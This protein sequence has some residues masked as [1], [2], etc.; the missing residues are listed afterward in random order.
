MKIAAFTSINASY[1]PNA[2]ILAKSV[3]RFQPDWD[4]YLLFNDW[5][6]DIIRWENE[7]F[8][9][10]VFADWLDTGGDWFRWA[11]K[12]SVVEFCTATKGVMSQYLLKNLRYDAVVYIDPDT[13]LFSPLEEVITEFSEKTAD[14]ILTPHLTDRE[15]DKEG[16]ASHEMAALKHGTFNLGFFAILNSPNGNKF[17]DWWADRL[18]KYSFIDFNSGLFTDQKWCNL[19][20]YIFDGVKVFTH[21]TYNVATWNMI[22]RKITKNAKGDWLV[23]REPLRF[24]HFSGF[25]HD[26][27]WADRELI[28]FCEPDDDTRLLWKYYKKKYKENTLE[29]YVNW[30]WEYTNGEVKITTQMRKDI[31][32]ECRLNP[33]DY[34]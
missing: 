4:F 11:F 30:K 13:V 21:R 33:Y 8:D 27:E 24:Y 31:L 28:K 18:L 23:D 17:L 9:D 26:F 20:P 10:V 34:L 3:K 15:Y 1:I 22:N 32:S 16:I 29:C 5:T 6:P 12:Y 19:A 25:G 14:V 2:R 7:P